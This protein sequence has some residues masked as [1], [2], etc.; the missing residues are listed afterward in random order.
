MLLIF[1]VLLL[2]VRVCGCVRQKP[3]AIPSFVYIVISFYDASESF[4][5]SQ[6][7]DIFLFF[8]SPL[9]RVR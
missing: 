8:L 9:T 6:C 5:T 4:N 1:V 3:T 7:F 2:R